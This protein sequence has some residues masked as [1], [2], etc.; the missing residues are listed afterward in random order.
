MK[1]STRQFIVAVSILAFIVLVGTTLSLAASKAPTP[2]VVSVEERIKTL[3]TA[4]NITPEQEELWNN[5]AQVMRDNSKTMEALIAARSA[6]AGTTNAVEDF[7]SYG[8]ITQAHADGIQKFIPVF[9]ALYNN[10]SD[11]QKKNAD[12]VFAQ[13]HQAKSKAK[14]K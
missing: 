12:T 8:E 11:A 4:L 6:K 7:K 5:V 3:H 14:G 10:M 9:E 13:R 2:K 1:R